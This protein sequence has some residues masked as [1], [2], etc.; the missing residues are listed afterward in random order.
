MERFDAKMDVEYLTH[1]RCTSALSVAI[2]PLFF[3][4]FPGPDIQR[5]AF[6]IVGWHWDLLLNLG[7]RGEIGL[8]IS[9]KS[10]HQ[11]KRLCV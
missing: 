6:Y 7:A 9:E 8:P 4:V 11:D 3:V 5:L 10:P 2:N 1:C